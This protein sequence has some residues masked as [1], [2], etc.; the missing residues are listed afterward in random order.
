MGKT[1]YDK[2]KEI[3]KGFEGQEIGFEN[4]NSLI[5]QKIGSDRRTTS[6]VM[7]LMLETNLIKDIGKMHFLVLGEKE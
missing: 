6:S 5:L 3:L 2:C 1:Q 4:L 7:R